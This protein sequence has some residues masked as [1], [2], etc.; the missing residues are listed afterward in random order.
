M[1]I[2]LSVLSVQQKQQLEEVVYSSRFAIALFFSPDV[3]FR[4]S[5]SARYV[6]N[7][8]IIR[9]MAADSRKR[10]AGQSASSPACVYLPVCLPHHSSIHV[11]VH[12][13]TPGCGPSLVVHT[14]VR[15]GQEHLEKD[16]EEVQTIVLQELY[17]LLP[18]LPQPISIKCQ[19]WRYS[20]V[21]FYRMIV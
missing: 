15:F 6:P 17:K 4:F 18:D 19:K 13:D 16:K 2:C 12:P 8:H 14:S 20:Q 1:S 9:Y 3:V 11:C 10:N 21:T 7:N 5:W